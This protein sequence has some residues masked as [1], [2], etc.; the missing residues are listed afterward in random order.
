MYV[1]L[2]LEEVLCRGTWRSMR[3]SGTNVEYLVNSQVY[4]LVNVL[5]AVRIERDGYPYNDEVVA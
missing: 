4:Q 2:T 3:Q 1:E 5:V